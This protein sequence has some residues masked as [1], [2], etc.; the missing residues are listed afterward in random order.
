M[1]LLMQIMIKLGQNQQTRIVGGVVINL[2]VCRVL[3]QNIIKKTN[4]M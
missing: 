3:Y 1:N 2:R 4:F